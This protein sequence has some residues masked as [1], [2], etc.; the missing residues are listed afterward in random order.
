MVQSALRDTGVVDLDVVHQGLLKLGSAVESGLGG[1]LGNTAVEALDQ[2]VGLR[3]PGRTKPMLDAQRATP[4]VEVM[5]AAGGA[6]LALEAV[7]EARAVVGEQLVDAHRGGLVQAV[8]EV[9]RAGGFHVRIDAHEHPARGPVDAHV[10]VAPSGL[11]GHLRQ[12][13]D[14][15]V[16]EARLVVLEALGRG[17]LGRLPTGGGLQLAQVVHAVAAQAAV[18]RRA[19]SLGIDELA[20]DHQQIVQRQQQQS[21]QLHHDGFLCRAERGAE[22][23]GP[24]AAV[25]HAVAGLPFRSG[26]LGDV[27]PA[28]QLCRAVLGRLD[29]RPYSRGGA[30]LWMDLAHVVDLCSGLLNTSR[31]TCLARYSGQLRMGQ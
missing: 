28:G 7:G 11:V 22:L 6:R 12:V 17:R 23:V 25:F 21:A 18:Q 31:M 29:L 3:V 30:R 20:G 13:L 24:M 16:H 9:D 1:D 19:R 26:R 2:A 8:D 27:V 5:L 10:Q 14:V 4:H 15:H